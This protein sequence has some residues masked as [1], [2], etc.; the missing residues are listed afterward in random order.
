MVEP[1]D[2][3]APPPPPPD[4][5]LVFTMSFMFDRPA[6]NT[7]AADI[8]FIGGGAE[9]NA[10]VTPNLVFIKASATAKALFSPA[11]LLNAPAN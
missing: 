6:A 4:G 2:G 8:K 9:P 10:L 3:I 7:A 5:I 1:T 11:S